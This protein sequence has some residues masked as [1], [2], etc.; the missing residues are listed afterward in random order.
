[1]TPAHEG[2]GPAKSTD[3][4]RR[5]RV[6]ICGLTRPADVDAAVAAGADAVGFVSDVPIETPRAVDGERAAALVD[7]TPPFVTTVLVT[8]ATDPDRLEQL[9]AHVDPDAMQL[10]GE[11]TDE[12]LAS[13]ASSV[14]ADLLLAVDAAAGDVPAHYDD[15][16]DALVVDSVTDSGAGGTGETHDWHVT[17]ERAAT[18]SSPVVLAGGLTPENVADAVRV[19]NPFAVDVSTGV[20]AT[21]GVKDHD[22]IDD[23]V[24]RARTAARRPGCP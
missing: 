6:K 1:M 19:A 3:V 10:H 15:R 8:M 24:E 23:F 5:P 9:A 13:L 12:E 21:G 16:A 4:A 18:L 7:R 2:D 17:A 11:R 20:E 22:A 14:S